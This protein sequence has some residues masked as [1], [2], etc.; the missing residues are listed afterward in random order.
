[1]TPAGS[2]SLSPGN[3]LFSDSETESLSS[4]P[5][6][7]KRTRVMEL[8]S[9]DERPELYTYTVEKRKS[10]KKTSEDSIPLPTPFPLPKHYRRDIE[11]ALNA[12]KM[13]RE[14]K[15]AFLSTVASTMLAY[16]Q[17]PSKEDYTNV[18]TS[19]CQE[20]TFFKSPIGSPEVSK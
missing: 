11:V 17:Y 13:T 10:I 15:R 7:R 4:M 6:S 5:A 2:S 14:T 18:A 20:Y 12:K 16:K 8:D 9:D 3:V 19:I 1:M